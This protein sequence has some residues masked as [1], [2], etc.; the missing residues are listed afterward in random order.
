MRASETTGGQKIRWTK[1]G[2]TR[3]GVVR[4]WD[5]GEALIGVFAQHI[6][7]ISPNQDVELVK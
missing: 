4:A 2:K 3:E 6:E 1:D 7:L 5:E